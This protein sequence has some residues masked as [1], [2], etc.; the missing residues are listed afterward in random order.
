MNHP[1]DG[2]LPG[3]IDPVVSL[4][5][6][7]DGIAQAQPQVLRHAFSHQYRFFVILQVR[8]SETPL[9]LVMASST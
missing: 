7:N 8:P 3:G 5:D 4:A 9:R 1:L 2:V 6:Q